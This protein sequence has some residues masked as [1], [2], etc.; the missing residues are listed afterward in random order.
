MNP[1]RIEIRCSVAGHENFHVAFIGYV[2]ALV[3]GI[4]VAISVEMDGVRTPV[5][6]GFPPKPSDRTEWLRTL[7]YASAGVNPRA[8]AL[9][10]AVTPR[11]REIRD[12]DKTYGLAAIST[13]RGGP[14]DFLSTKSVGGFAVRDLS[15]WFVGLIDHL[16]NSAARGPGEIA[17]PRSAVD[18]WLS[19]QVDLLDG[20]LSPMESVLASY[21]LCHFDYDPI[22]VLQGI[23]VI[24]STGH[25][26]WPSQSLS[27]LLRSGN[28]LGFRVSDYG[29]LRL[30][31]YGEQYSIAGFAT[32]LVL[33]TGQFNDAAMSSTRPSQPKSLIGVIHRALVAQGANPTWIVHPRMYPG[34]FSRCDCLEVK[35]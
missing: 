12:G 21:S 10:D 32:C 1:D 6:K 28:R 34:P 15:E 20:D 25:V 31:Q 29:G 35:I 3:I 5:H 8:A 13:V 2:A 30:E 17:A 23:Q 33:G 26:F 11:L 19:E 9:V 14:C 24:T 22:D 7:S 18:V 27:A 4:D 16:P